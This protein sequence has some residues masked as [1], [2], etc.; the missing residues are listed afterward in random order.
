MPRTRV[1]IPGFVDLQV[2]G[3]RGVDFS[4]AE[5]AASAFGRACDELLSLGTAAFLPTVITSPRATYERNL[6]L[7][8]AAIAG[9][10]FRGRLL[11]IHLEGPFISPEPGAVGAHAPQWVRP[12]DTG[13]LDSLVEWS[14]GTVR[15]L[16]VAPERPGALDLIAHAVRAGVVVSIG[17][18]LATESVI[19]EAAA[20]GAT[21]F[22]HLGNGMPN[23]V[24]RHANPMWGAL[25]E[26][27]LTA[28]IIT[29]GHHLPPAVIKSVLRAKGVERSIVVSD[30]SPMA[31][32]PPGR[33]EASGNRIV[34]EPD[35]K[36]HNPEKGCLV[37]SSATMLACMNHIASLGLLSLQELLAVGFH[38]P[39]A[40]IGVAPSEVRDGGAVWYDSDKRMFVVTADRGGRTS[41][42]RRGPARRKHGGPR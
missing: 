23:V 20:A 21:A 12:P 4:S 39:L 27:R 13:L 29:D 32:M 33:Y 1:S 38:N 35:G 6:P 41:P 17:H 34:L 37:G 9:N 40:L 31:G 25:A 7:I 30:A 16:T 10:E 36:L 18:T 14:A 28:M 3:H 24:P 19:A 5:L 22:T 8:G 2:N 42:V 15:L 11:G 26:E